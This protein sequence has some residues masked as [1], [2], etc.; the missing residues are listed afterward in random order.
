MRHRLRATVADAMTLGNG[1]AG[2]LSIVAWSVE[3]GPLAG[4]EDR[5]AA[6]ILIAVGVILDGLDGIVARKWGSTGLGNELDA[7]C[8]AITF[9]VAPAVFILEMHTY[10]R[11]T[12]LGAFAAGAAFVLIVAGMLRLARERTRDGAT[13]AGVPTPWSAALITIAL[14]LG[15]DGAPVLFGVLALA[16]LNV[17]TIPYP[18]SRGARSRGCVPASASRRAAAW[19]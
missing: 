4:L 6:G 7:M 18:K 16:A 13:F 3:L 17:S 11:G 10:A 8:D 15:W 5:Y 14:L 2:Y 12:W 19:A 1:I 9:C